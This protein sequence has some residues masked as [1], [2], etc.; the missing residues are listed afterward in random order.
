[1]ITRA[2]G[3]GESPQALAEQ[4][5]C[6]EALMRTVDRCIDLE[7]ALRKIKAGIGVSMSAVDVAAEVDY[8]LETAGFPERQQ[9]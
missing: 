4:M 8:A 2:D 3:S 5:P 7:L 6:E 1:M 9:R